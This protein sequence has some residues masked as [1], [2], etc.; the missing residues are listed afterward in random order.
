MDKWLFR[1]QF[2]CSDKPYQPNAFWKIEELPAG[3]FLSVHQD[4]P[5]KCRV[6]GQKALVILGL[7]FDPLK[8]NKTTQELIDDV[9]THFDGF[10]DLFTTTKPFSGRWALIAIENGTVRLFTDACGFRTI[11]YRYV[12]QFF[13]FASQPELLKKQHPLALKTEA[14]LTEFLQSEAYIRGESAWIG[15]Q[16]IYEDCYHLLPNHYFD[17]K[18]AAPVRFYPNHAVAPVVENREAQLSLICRLLQ[19][20]YQAL[21]RQSSLMLPVTS[22]WDSRLLLAA[23]RNHLDDI[24]C[25]VQQLDGMDENHPDIQIPKSMS[26]QCGFSF[27]VHHLP[28]ENVPDW[29]WQQIR[30]NVTNPR[31]LPKSSIIYNHLET[32]DQRININGNGSEICRNYFDKYGKHQGLKYTL[33]ELQFLLYGKNRVPEMFRV[34]IASWMQDFDRNPMG[35]FSI[36]DLLYWEQRIGNWGAQFPA[37]QDIARDEV[38]PFNCRLLLEL[39]NAFPLSERSAPNFKLYHDLIAHMW[40]DLLDY[41]FNPHLKSHRA[42]FKRLIRHAIPNRVDTKIR[43]WL[44]S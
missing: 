38:S 15:Q 29:F 9:W 27:E 40:P 19:G 18:Q 31:C 16:T 14:Y 42:D 28:Q 5:Y 3:Y 25:Y 23:A 8:P 34:E 32:N 26:E 7:F 33:D 13:H 22:G 43:R 30:T 44:K 17:T 36:G 20:T 24:Q 1:R 12:N 39:M 6:E 4:L 37:E 11:F 2:L 10:D 21:I 41:P 35:Y